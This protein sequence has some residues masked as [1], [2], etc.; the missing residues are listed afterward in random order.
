[1][2]KPRASQIS[3]WGLFGVLGFLGFREFYLVNVMAY[4]G[5]QDIWNSKRFIAFVLISSLSLL[6]YL[7]VGYLKIIRQK[8]P[9]YCRFP[10]GL[11]YTAAALLVLL[12]G[13]IKWILPQ[14][15]NFTFG[16]WEEMLFIYS[17]A[18]AAVWLMQAQNENQSKSL[19]TIAALVMAGGCGHAILLKLCQVTAYPFTTFWSEGN[20]F[21]DYSTLFG[22]YRYLVPSGEKIYAFITWGMQVPW[23]LPFIFPKLTIGAF[24]LWYQ[25]MWILP[26][27]LLGLAAAWKK[28]LKGIN[29]AIALVFAGWAFLF[30][31]QGPIYTPLI[32]AGLLT[33]LAVRAKLPVG[34]ALIVLAS[35]YAKYS[36]WT[37]T[38]SPGLWAAMLT[39][40]DISSPNFF[41]E[42]FKKLVKPVAL[43]ISGYFGGQILPSI[44]KNLSV[45]SVK[46]V[47]DVVGSATRQPLLWER[48]LPNPTFPPGILY[49]LLWAAL[50]VVVLLVA[51]LAAR[52]W[53]VN[54][55]QGLAMLIIA[56]AYLATGL[57]A[58][59]KI[60]GGSNLHNLDNFLVTLV[61]ISAAALIHLRKTNF[62]FNSKPI[63]VI[64]VGIALVAPV[65]FCLRGGARLS[66]PDEAATGEALDVVTSTVEKF[67]EKGEILFIDQRQLLT[68]GM[69][70]DVPLVDDYEKKY[71]M[72]QAL[73]DNSVYFQDFSRDLVNARFALIVN[74]PSNYV[75]RGS[76]SSF[77]QE[78]DAYVKWVTIP[79]ICTYE[80]IYTSTEIGVEL[81]VPRQTPRTDAICQESLAQ[82]LSSQ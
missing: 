33:L 42:G 35:Y 74:E 5:T 34:I 12:P 41:R 62:D 27:L 67:K 79:L 55:M 1:M 76:E 48:L 60:G 54:W 2:N 40:L 80:P 45:A 30:L 14:P 28:P 78:N 26:T 44:I 15:A 68:F 21:F 51:L 25:L 19:L 9:V 72:D 29:L 66:L 63:L 13:L 61:M 6:A 23:A 8:S 43:G 7:D 16:Y 39:L 56:G 77:G 49:G 38:Y 53:K 24:R 32:L 81:L 47:P 59:V 36:R 82:L 70:R 75:I 46:L 4:V 58:S 3:L 50:P 73:A 57:I 37:W 65:T 22:S 69:L 64:L 20:R 52:A 18:L 17:A 10:A 71:L 31:D 11:R